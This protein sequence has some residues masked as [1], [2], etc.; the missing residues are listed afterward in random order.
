MAE[1]NVQ[2]NWTLKQSNNIEVVLDLQA[3]K[4]DG[5]FVGTASFGG[6]KGGGFGW[7]HDGTFVFRIVWSNNSE[8]VYVGVLDSQRHLNGATFDVSHPKTVA[9]WDTVRTF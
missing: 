7:V 5:T 4:P 2:G 3:P 8:G 6:T 1:F 9:T